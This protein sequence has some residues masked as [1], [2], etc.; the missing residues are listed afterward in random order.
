MYSS[1]RASFSNIHPRAQTGTAKQHAMKM[2]CNSSRKSLL[3]PLPRMISRPAKT[4]ENGDQLA[5][6]NLECVWYCGSCCGCGLKKVVFIKS[7][8]S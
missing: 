8:F 4:V 3:L 6:T 7:T 1:C 2:L 5:A